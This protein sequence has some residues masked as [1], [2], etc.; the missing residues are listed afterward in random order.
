MNEILF[1]EKKILSVVKLN[2]FELIFKQ[3]PSTC[4]YKCGRLGLFKRYLSNTR[5]WE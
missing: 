1:G 4:S 3:T 5:N 2:I